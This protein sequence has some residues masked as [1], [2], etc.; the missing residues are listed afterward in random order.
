MVRAQLRSGLAHVGLALREPEEFARRFHAGE[1]LY[2]SW[3][4]AA[5]ALTAIL[6]TLT[7]GLT[8][9]LLGGPRDHPR[10]PLLHSGGRPGLGHRIAVSLHLQQ[11]DRLAAPRQHH[12]SGRAR[13]HKLGRPRDDR[14]D[15]HQLV[16]YRGV[17]RS[18][19][20][21]SARHLARAQS[22]SWSLPA[23]AC[24]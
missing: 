18:D 8:M 19:R 14:V 4:F 16:L 9:G 1:V 10:C 20:R 12:A 17:R 21:P 23:S 11:P 13:D 5:L 3:I 2:T 7:Y 22:I 6:G 15:P 24:A